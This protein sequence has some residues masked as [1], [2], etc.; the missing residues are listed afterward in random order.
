MCAVSMIGDFYKD[1]WTSPL[2]GKIGTLPWPYDYVQFPRS[3]FEALKREVLEMKELLKRA[4]EY[5]KKNN[6]PHCEM[7]DKVQILRNVARIVGISLDDV[8]EYK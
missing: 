5:D 3:E 7:A 4:A 1:K 6:E 8:I 2:T